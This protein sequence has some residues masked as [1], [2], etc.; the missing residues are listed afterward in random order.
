MNI[1]IN[2]YSHDQV[3]T[4]AVVK[5]NL[6]QHNDVYVMCSKLLSSMAANAETSSSH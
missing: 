2:E 3:C 6:H 4:F 5:K 1:T